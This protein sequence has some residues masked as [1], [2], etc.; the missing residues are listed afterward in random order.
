MFWDSL[1][2]N[3]TDGALIRVIAPVNATESEAVAEAQLIEFVNA[4][5]RHMGPFVPS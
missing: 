3:R 4:A 1:T 5:T 2:R